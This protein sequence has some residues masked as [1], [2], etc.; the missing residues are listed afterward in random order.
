VSRRA[1]LAWVVVALGVV[2]G[3]SVLVGFVGPKRGFQWELA[4][5][6]GTALGTT[7]LAAATGALAYSTWSD[8]R[9]TWRLA[10]LTKRDQDERERPIVIQQ[11]AVWRG[12]GEMGG[13]QEGPLEVSLR[14]VGLGPALRVEVTAAYVDEEFKPSIT[15]NPYIV[16]AIAP[17]M[18]RRD[19]KAAAETE[20]LFEEHVARPKRIEAT[21]AAVAADAALAAEKAD[22]ARRNRV[23]EHARQ[24]R[25]RVEAELAAAHAMTARDPAGAPARIKAALASLSDEDRLYLE[26][27]VRATRRRGHG[28]T[29]RRWPKAISASAPPNLRKARGRR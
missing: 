9:A 19:E 29:A 6:F 28:M 5:I 2:L 15:P 23:A 3:L 20:A 24:H 4:S 27:R 7:L 11:R 14:N 18:R 22:A 12:G 16:P 21:L 26:R 13:R 25:A 1:L 8:V 10:E 17:D